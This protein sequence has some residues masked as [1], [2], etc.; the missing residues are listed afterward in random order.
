MVKEVFLPSFKEIN[1]CIKITVLALKNMEVNTN[2]LVDPKYDY[3]FS[4]EEVNKL[5][6][7]GVPFREA[8]KQVGELIE[9]GNFKPEKRVNHTHQGS[10]GNL[11]LNKILAKK[12]SIIESFGFDKVEE[13][14]KNLVK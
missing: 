5:V 7:K 1:D 14:L 12:N 3:I 13:I 11:C 2:V 4:V 6:L 9:E 10:I 8:Y